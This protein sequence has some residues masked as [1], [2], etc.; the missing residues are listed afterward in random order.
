[1]KYLFVGRVLPVVLLFCFGG[2]I[3]LSQ[4]PNDTPLNNAAVV[5]LVKAGFKEKSILSIIAS[6]P[7]NFDLSTERMI[8][9]KRSGVSERIILAMLAR[10]EGMM[11]IDDSWSEDPFFREGIEPKRTDP[12]KAPTTGDGSSTDIFGS[13]G[14]VK[15]ETRSRGGNGSIVDDTITTGSATVRIIKP[16]AEANTPAKLERTATLTNAS[17][18]ELVEAGFSEGTIIRRID[19]SAVDF[20]LSAGQQ[21]ELRRRRVSDKV[22]TAMQTAMGLE[23]GTT[24][25]LSGTDDKPKTH[26]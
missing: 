19:Q 16:P 26:N 15:G 24:K 4:R 13:S 20:D 7:S 21:K 17:I 14:G 5:K 9:L 10:Q 11:A 2:S 1:M 3:A 23:P 22:I 25:P 6:R 12:L 8:D 18:I